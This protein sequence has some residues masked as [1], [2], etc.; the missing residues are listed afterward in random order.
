MKRSAIIP[1]LLVA[2]LAWCAAAAPAPAAEIVIDCAREIGA[3]RPL[4]GVNKGPLEAGGL[5]DL[6]AHFRELAVPLV[7]LHDCNWPNP[8]VVDVH[9]VFP[10][11]DADPDDPKSYDFARTDEYL[12]AVH[13]TGARVVFRLGESIE[14]APVKRHVHPPR[15]ARK[16]AAVC[17]GIIRHYNEGW[18]DGFRYGIEYWEIWN[19]PDNRPAMWTGTDEDYF[20]LYSAA[21]KAIKARFPSLRVGGPGL[22]NTGR[23]EGEALE[24]APFFRRF[25]EHC[26]RDAAPLDFFSWHAYD[27]D[28]R[29]FA[30]R[31]RAVRRLLDREGFTQAESHLNEWN[32]LPDNDWSPATLAGQGAARQRFYDRVGG[33]E[34]AAFVACTL[35]LLQDAPVD[36]ANYFAGDTGGFGL[37][38]PHGAPRESFYAVKAFQALTET[39]TRLKAAGDEPGRLGAAAGMGRQRATV[40]VLV[41]NFGSADDA[42]G[43]TFKNLPWSDETIYEVVRVDAANEF[44]R[45]E[46]GALRPGGQRIALTLRAPALC[47]VTARSGGAAR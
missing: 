16:W 31:A 14:H 22:G 25:L 9:V 37:F 32:Y 33:A 40:T 6:S 3:F 11:F 1:A 4:H 35:M 26:K 43:L 38:S 2:H 44:Q 8:D 45:R 46:A 12:A 34:G 10:N 29:T 36:A 39:G 15:D 19:E 21:S 5:T 13:K 47:L 41:S 42:V 7:R 27:A 20:R 18:A 17:V 28:P 30:A 24:P 23:L